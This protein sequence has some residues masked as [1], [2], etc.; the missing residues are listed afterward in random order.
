M[1]KFCRNNERKY[2]RF[3]A[4]K[5]YGG[6][7]TA[8]CMGCNMDCAFCWSWRTRAN[9]EMGEFYSPE[10]VAERLVKVAHNNG[11]RAVRISGNE[12]TLCREHLLGV[13][14]EVEDLDSSLIFILETNGIEIGRDESYAE[15]LSKF[16]NLHVRVS[17]KT[18]SPE[19]FE[20]ITGRPKEWFEL[21]IK[22]VERLH[23]KVS[24]HPAVVA[25]YAGEYLIKRLREISPEIPAK[26]EHESLVIY[27]HVKKRMRARGLI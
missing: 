9:P 6:I 27:T 19:N 25:E 26:L 3:R 4:D 11:F 17:F 10:E 20:I 7:A 2:Y 14:G 21:Q 23:G 24:F 8:D 22:A 15:D 18:R 12:P 5:Y 16:G 1:Q 13:I